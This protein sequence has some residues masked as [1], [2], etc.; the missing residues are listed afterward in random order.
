MHGLQQQA[1]SSV[2]ENATDTWEVPVPGPG[3]P[4]CPV[5]SCETQEVPFSRSFPPEYALCSPGS[6]A[7]NFF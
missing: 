7:G 5:Q 4:A 2:S 1:G 6:D 3:V